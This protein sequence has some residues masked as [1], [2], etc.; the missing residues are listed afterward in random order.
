METN[1]TFVA[2]DA[3]FE[4]ILDAHVVLVFLSGWEHSAWGL[5]AALELRRYAT[6]SRRRAPRV[7]RTETGKVWQPMRRGRQR[8]S[9]QV[10]YGA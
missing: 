5:L 9:R 4:V 3:S 6:T 1:P 10:W 2:S 8:A 7:Q